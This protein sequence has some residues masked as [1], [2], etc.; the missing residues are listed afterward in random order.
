MRQYWS[1]E[2]DLILKEFYLKENGIKLI[3]ERLPYKT[4][5]SI[6]HRANWIGL[7]REI[8]FIKKE[9]FFDIPNELNCSIAGYLSADGCISIS[10]K[11]GCRVIMTI[12]KEDVSYLEELKNILGFNGKL[13]YRFRKNIFI[14]KRSGKINY[15]DSESYNL[16]IGAAQKWCEK[17]KTIW[18]IIEKKTDRLIPPNLIELNHCLAFMQGSIN[19]DGSLNCYNYDYPVKGKHFHLDLLGTE[20]LLQFFEKLV[21]KIIPEKFIDKIPATV[22]YKKEEKIFNYQINGVRA[23]I[24]GKMILSMK[25]PEIKRKW[26]FLRE[27]INYIETEKPKKSIYWLKNIITKEQI[28][29]LNKRNDGFPL[30]LTEHFNNQQDIS[31]E[32][33]S[34]ISAIV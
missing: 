34:Q 4:Y 22:N 32:N 9:N 2:E 29:F 8:Q 23:Y 26:D 31:K 16:Q 27:Y 24:I 33:I 1:K 17:L 30:F 14:K 28:N 20:K 12:C 6:T 21:N 10:P 5:S 18:N 7:K 13:Y 3:Q 11:T 15:F 19:G 25:L